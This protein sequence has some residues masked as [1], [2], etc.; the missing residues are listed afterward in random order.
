M[1]RAVHAVAVSAASAYAGV[2]LVIGVSLGA[3]WW[4]MAPEAY[5]AEFEALFPL[6]VPSIA[7]TLLPAL[8]AGVA[9]FRSSPAGSVARAAWLR[10]LVALG[11]SIAITVVYH[12]PA[13]LRVWSGALGAAA[14]HTEL[15]WWLVFHLARWLAA[16]AAVAF[17]FRGGLEPS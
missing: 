17:A 13:N 8:G 16:A 14:L 10:F 2:M 11:V 7:L 4:S 9:S 5:A 6:L 3:R 1:T 15:A 12:V